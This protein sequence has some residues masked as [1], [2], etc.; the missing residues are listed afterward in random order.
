MRQI[1][2]ALSNSLALPSARSADKC[3]ASRDIAMLSSAIANR[4]QIGR[5]SA[6]SYTFLESRRRRHA[7]Q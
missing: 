5:N 1:G 6:A 3:T 7:R 2:L 4:K